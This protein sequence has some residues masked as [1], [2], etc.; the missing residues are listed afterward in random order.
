ML[1]CATVAVLQR[2]GPDKRE[3]A[4]ENIFATV[5]WHLVALAPMQNHVEM[6]CL[7]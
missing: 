1:V 2:K 3:E 7:L 4:K 6:C 5:P